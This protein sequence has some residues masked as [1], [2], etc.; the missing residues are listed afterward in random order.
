MAVSLSK[1]QRATIDN[2]L[3]LGLIGLGWDTNRYD[4]G[5]DFDL[6]ASVFLLGADDKVVRDEDFVFYNNLV[7]R[8]GAVVHQG[9]NLTGNG[10]GDDEVIVIDFSKIPQDIHKIAV[11]ITIHEAEAR[12]QNFGQ[13]SNAYARFARMRDEFDLQGETLLQFDLE[14]EFSIETSLV[15]CEVYRKN[16]EWKFKAVASGYKGGLETLCRNYG[17]NL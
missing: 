3:R 1:G 14:E 15:I 7:G 6:D 11:T 8:D 9:D 17:V 5:Y 16:G 10:S 4:G 13:I 12:N 2:S